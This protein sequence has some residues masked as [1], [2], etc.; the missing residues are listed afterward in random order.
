MKRIFTFLLVTFCSLATAAEADKFTL[1]SFN[2]VSKRVAT[3]EDNGS[4]AYLLLTNSTGTEA[5]EALAY[6]RVPPSPK[7]WLLLMLENEGHPPLAAESAS[8]HAVIPDARKDEM[9]LDWS[10]DGTAVVLYRGVQPIAFVNS[11]DQKGRSRAIAKAAPFTEPWDEALHVKLFQPDSRDAQ[12]RRA[13][14]LHDR[15]DYSN[16]LALYEKI[17]AANP[18]D[19]TALYE[20]GMT[21]T[22]TKDYEACISYANRGIAAKG[23]RP[24]GLYALLGSCQDYLGHTDQALAAFAEGVKLDSQDITLNFNYGSTLAR[25]GDMAKAR[26]HL[27]IAM[28]SKRPYATPRLIY[29]SI[30]DKEGNAGAALAMYTSFVMVDLTSPRSKEASARI[31]ELLKAGSAPDAKGKPKAV[32][33]AISNPDHPDSKIGQTLADAFGDASVIYARKQGARGTPADHAVD[34]LQVFFASALKRPSPELK[35]SVL[36]PHGLELIDAFSKERMLEPFLYLVAANAGLE[37]SKEWG[38]AHQNESIR[39]LLMLSR[40]KASSAR[41]AP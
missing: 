27:K 7:S 41:P 36:W 10:P 16:A 25:T 30:L 3:L 31:V 24:G 14:S 22:V 26:E 19:T 11:A 20:A 37:G 8:E 5:A 23:P 13:I 38:Q 4:V 32:A 40:L 2:D 39:T 35:D 21:A 28:S 18:A 1:Q 34:A 6:S 15:G 17:I 12:L 9:W 29:G 33:L